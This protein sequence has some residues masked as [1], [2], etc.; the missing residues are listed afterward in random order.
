MP[1]EEDLQKL[2]EGIGEGFGE[3]DFDKL[4]SKDVLYEPMVDLASKVFVLFFLLLF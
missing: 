1:S 4:L 2:I 3:E